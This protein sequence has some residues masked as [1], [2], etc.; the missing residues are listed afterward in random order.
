MPRTDLCSDDEVRALVHAF[1][2][3]VR[4]DAMLG[5]I[6]ES[7]VHDWDSH[8]SRLT[9]F[10]SAVLRGTGRFT[11]A[12]MP[13]HVALPGLNAELFQRWLALFHETTAAHPNQAMG[14]YADAMA[15]RIAQSLWY[16]YQVSRRPDELPSALAPHG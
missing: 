3:K 13:R 16:G 12:P 11:G 6:F 7:H 9:D 15:E 4:R 2:A 1:Y 10:W 5:P 8:L 14:Q